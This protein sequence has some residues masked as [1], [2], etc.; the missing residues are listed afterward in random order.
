M[1]QTRHKW[2]MESKT[3]ADKAKEMDETCPTFN[4]KNTSEK[5]HLHDKNVSISYEYD[6]DGTTATEPMTDD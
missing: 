3:E 1:G 6:D 5:H 2:I 4:L